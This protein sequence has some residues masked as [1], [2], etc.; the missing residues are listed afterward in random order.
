[1][2]KLL[3]YRKVLV[4]PYS[5]V[6]CQSLAGGSSQG[7]GR[8]D[9]RKEGKKGGKEKGSLNKRSEHRTANSNH[10]NWK[11]SNAYEHPSSDQSEKHQ[12]S[13]ILPGGQSKGGTPVAL[14]LD[15]AAEAPQP[16]QSHKPKELAAAASQDPMSGNQSCYVMHLP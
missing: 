6:S 12:H 16:L 9:R 5:V 3:P 7:G 11:K 13:Q 2:E 4:F 10:Q 8:K 14:A 1:M 15:K